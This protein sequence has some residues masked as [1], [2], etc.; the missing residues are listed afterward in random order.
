MLSNSLP[1]MPNLTTTVWLLLGVT[2]WH[3]F[4]CAFP[5][6]KYSSKVQV[7]IHKESIVGCKCRFGCCR[8]QAKHSLMNAQYFSICKIAILNDA[9]RVLDSQTKQSQTDLRFLHLYL[10]PCYLWPAKFINLYMKIP[11]VGISWFLCMISWSSVDK[12]FGHPVCVCIYLWL[13][14]SLGLF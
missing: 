4:D 12:C 3:Y 5:K 14:C 13:R 1:L 9:E 10:A 7:L 11:R 2:M 8:V 6:G